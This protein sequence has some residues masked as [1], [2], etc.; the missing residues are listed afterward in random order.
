MRFLIIL[1][2][3]F[4]A[5]TAC[6]KTDQELLTGMWKINEIKANGEMMFSTDKAEQGKIIDRVIV[7]QMEQLPPE[8]QNQEAMMR[9]LFSQQ[10]TTSAKTT[11]EF[12]EDNTFVSIRYEG[13]REVKTNGRITLDEEKKEITMKSDSDEHFT[14][15]LTDDLLKLSGDSDGEKIELSFKRK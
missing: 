7:A 5:F 2:F 4:F 8:A 6:Q 14:Y 10:M 1:P 11:L 15:Q 9:K 13:S 12:K 3:I